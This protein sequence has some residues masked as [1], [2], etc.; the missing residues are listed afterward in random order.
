MTTPDATIIDG[1]LHIPAALYMA[2]MAACPAVALLAEEQRWWLVPL[3]AGAGGLQVKLRN[4][5]GDR[6]VEVREFLRQQGIDDDSPVLTVRLARDLQR[7]G[8]EL[9]R[10]RCARAK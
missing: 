2:H 10:D 7:G 6:V 1:R 8:F 3:L 5:R 4:A 9:I